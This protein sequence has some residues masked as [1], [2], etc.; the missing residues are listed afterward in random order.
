MNDITVYSNA[1][2]LHVILDNIIAN[3]I[4][5]SDE[6]GDVIV[7]G[8]LENNQLTMHISDQG[9]GI[10][11]NIKE[12]VFEAFFQGPTPI[13]NQ[14]KGS[15]LGLTIVKELLMRLN[16]QIQIIDTENVRNT[17]TRG[18]TFEIIL[19]NVSFDSN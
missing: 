19:P 18:A 14:V 12:R 16:G 1:K 2:Q 17:E 8:K 5:Y 11:D 10:A 3:A 4:N 7:D 9:P 13:D 6:A 15:G